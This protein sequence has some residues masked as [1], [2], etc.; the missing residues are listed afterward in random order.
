MVEEGRHFTCRHCGAEG[1]ICKRCDRGHCYCSASCRESARQM[2]NGRARR[3]YQSSPAGRSGNARRQ[4]EW[5]GRK[6]SREK[7][8]GNLTHQGSPGPGLGV[9]IPPTTADAGVAVM[10]SAESVDRETVESPVSEAAIGA[11][12]LS[13]GVRRCTVCR[14]LVEIQSLGESPSHG[15]KEEASET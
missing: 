11:V 4:R 7:V 12:V 6:R 5:Y 8:A 3:R 2:R 10:E 1:W 13:S 15:H 14:R 9:I